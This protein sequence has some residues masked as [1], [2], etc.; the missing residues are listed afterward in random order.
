M[1]IKSY[2]LVLSILALTGCKVYNIP[3]NEFTQQIKNSHIEKKNVTIPGG[4]LMSLWAA[5]SLYTNGI[6]TLKGY[7]KKG[8]SK[9]IP[10]NAG[11]EVRFTTKDGKQT[12]YY[13]DSIIWSDTIVTGTTSRF[14]KTQKIIPIKNIVKVEVAN[15]KKGIR[16]N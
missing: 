5:D 6:H 9:E 14:L 2:L 11:T 4:G 1:K 13:F 7:D 3:V 12:V 10:V 15:D 16:Y 8:N